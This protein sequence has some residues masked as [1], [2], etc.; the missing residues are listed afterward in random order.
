[1]LVKKSYLSQF[2]NE[3]VYIFSLKYIVYHILYVFIFYKVYT[4]KN[5]INPLAFIWILVTVSLIYY[6][7]VTY[8][9]LKEMPDC[10]NEK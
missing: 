8:I 9:I 1:M 2:I 10:Q 4:N 6:F 5:N 3:L 7:L